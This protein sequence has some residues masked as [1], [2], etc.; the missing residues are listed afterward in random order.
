MT[1]ASRT[2]RGGLCLENEVQQLEQALSAPR[3]SCSGPVAGRD[4]LTMWREQTGSTN[5]RA[6]EAVGVCGT[7]SGPVRSAQWLPRAFPVPRPCLGLPRSCWV[8]TQPPA[9]ADF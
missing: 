2:T 1:T 6:K 7:R 9:S 4:S 5:L 3:F 8:G